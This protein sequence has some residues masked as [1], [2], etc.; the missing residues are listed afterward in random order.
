LNFPTQ[1]QIYRRLLAMAW[2][3]QRR[4]LNYQNQTA[5]LAALSNLDR[6]GPAAEA[7]PAL[8]QRLARLLEA[9]PKTLATGPSERRAV[10][11]ART[12]LEQGVAA[13][14]ANECGLAL[15][16]DGF[17]PLLSAWGDLTLLNRKKIAFLNSRT[18]RRLSPRDRWLRRTITLAEAE[19]A[20]ANTVL[21]SGYG[22]YPYEL[23]CFLAARRQT[24]LIMVCDGTLPLAGPEAIRREFLHRYQPLFSTGGTLVISGVTPG[25]P[26][27]RQACQVMRDELVAALADLLFGVEIRDR[28]NMFRLLDAGLTQGGRVAVLDAAENDRATAGNRRLLLRG[29]RPISVPKLPLAVPQSPPPPVPSGTTLVRNLPDLNH[30]LFHFTRSC[31]GPWP[32]QD[33]RDFYRSLVEED[34]AASHTA[35]DTLFRILTE[36][37]IRAGCRLTRKKIPAVSL[38]ACSPAELDDLIHWRPALGRWT[39]EP[40]G[41]GVAREA[42][43]AQGAEPVLYGDEELW[44]RLPPARQFLF[45]LHQDHQMDWTREKEWR[46][47]GD[48]MLDGLGRENLLAVVPRGWEHQ[49][50]EFFQG[51]VIAV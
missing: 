21:V 34:P 12:W 1:D 23:S 15:C 50:R 43:V 45:Q 9:A 13:L 14:T 38:T 32:G 20:P 19:L 22:N 26:P 36:K 30:F 31:P 44:R 24:G 3:A 6:S 37:R 27:A 33:L 4:D 25:R 7:H 47:P 5:L 46:C 17:G 28:G 2:L 42:A 16:P 18:P 29:A 40:F 51:R 49:V 11:Q 39:M 8:D 10:T 41:L 48:L 35:L